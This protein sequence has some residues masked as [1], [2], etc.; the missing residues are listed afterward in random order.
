M[1]KIRGNTQILDGSIEFGQLSTTAA[2]TTD[3][4]T[5]A[6]ATELARADAIKSYID[7]L[8][9]GTLKQPEAYDPTTTGNYPTTYGGVAIEAGDSYRITADQITIG[10]GSRDVNVEDL[11][12]ALIDNPGATTDADWMVAESNRAQAT[13][14][15]LGLA[16]IATQAE[17]DTGADDLR[18]VTPLKLATHLS[19]AGIQAYQFDNG[20]TV[21]TG[22]S[23]DTIELGGALT[24]DT[25]IDGR[26]SG[27]TTTITG[28]D[29]MGANTT[30]EVG[31][32][33]NL[34]ASNTNAGNGTVGNTLFQ[35]YINGFLVTQSGT[36]GDTGYFR[37]AAD[38]S[39]SFVARSIVDRGYV[40]DTV[41]N[42][43]AANGITN[44]SGT[45][46][47]GGTLTKITSVIGDYAWN[48]ETTDSANSS[49]NV[50][51]TASYEVYL[52]AQAIAN[53]QNFVKVDQNEVEISV[54]DNQGGSGTGIT[55]MEFDP[56]NH[57]TITAASGNGMQYAADYSANNAANNRWIPDKGYVDAAI[58]GVTL[59]AGDGLTLTG[60]TLDVVAADTSI[61]VNADDIAVTTG[62]ETVY[63]TYNG[64]SNASL[65]VTTNNGHVPGLELASHIYGARQFTNGAFTVNSGA[66]NTTLSTTQTSIL[67][68][69]SGTGTIT[70]TAPA[71]A[72]LLANAPTGGT[73]LAI[74]TTGYVDNAVGGPRKYNEVTTLNVGGQT[75]TLTTAPTTG[76]DNLVAYMNGVRLILTTDYTVTNATTG[77]ITFTAAQTLTAGDVVIFDYTDQ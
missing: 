70:L 38:Y 54:D 37:Y 10:G 25:T 61:T 43:N 1:A 51:S 28:T 7:Q 5:S 26:T 21:N 47:L 6:T 52:E 68:D 58:T 34:I 13:E 33:L 63:N 75:A 8:V 64:V 32:G 60:T 72:S 44:N 35:G 69:N 53:T 18:Y 56:A 76:A 49:A 50:R 14:S 3:L 29:G 39:A 74:A 36:N 30:L 42:I 9:D 71:D 66:Y 57:I 45:I 65:V 62:N 67:L 55:K 15:S 40:D 77:E 23:P 12:I 48:F 46:E 22:T 16:E 41:N 27:F 31:P 17:T 24:R 11:L 73:A 20:L 59:T 19:T 4:T 2:Y